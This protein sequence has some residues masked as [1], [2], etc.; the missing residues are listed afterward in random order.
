MRMMEMMID[1]CMYVWYDEYDEYDGDDGDDASGIMKMM[2]I[3][4]MTA[5]MT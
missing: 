2:F 3:E 4:T 1:V 5:L